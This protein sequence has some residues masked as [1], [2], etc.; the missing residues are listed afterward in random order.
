MLQSIVNFIQAIVGAIVQTIN[1]LINILS[2]VF[3]GSTII[4]TVLSWFPSIVITFATLSIVILIIK[5]VIGRD[6]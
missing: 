3:S 1:G 5:F 6:N 4:F 2:F